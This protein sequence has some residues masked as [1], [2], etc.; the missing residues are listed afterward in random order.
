MRF[1]KLHIIIISLLGTSLA[2]AQPTATTDGVTNVTD[3]SVTFNGTVEAASLT[4]TDYFFEYGTASDLTGASNTGTNNYTG[5][6]FPSPQAISIAQSGLSSETQYYYRLNVIGGGN[7]EGSIENFFT[8]S[9]VYANAISD[10]KV[11]SNSES[12]IHLEWTAETTNNDGYLILYSTGATA[13]DAAA[14]ISNAVAPAGQ[15]YSGPGVLSEIVT[16]SSTNN[17]DITGLTGATQYS[18]A[19]IPFN[20]DES[21]DET[22][23]YNTIT[24]SSFSAFTQYPQP[25]NHVTGI[26]HT[27]TASSI[28]LSF[29]KPSGTP[30]ADGYYISY[31]IGSSAPGNLGGFLDGTA[32]TAEAFESDVDGIFSLFSAASTVTANITGLSAN[33]SYSFRIVPFAS[34]PGQDSTSFNYKT[35]GEPTYTDIYTLAEEPTASITNF[36]KTGASTTQIDFSF[37]QYDISPGFANNGGF[38]LYYQAGAT[39]PGLSG[40]EDGID[41][42]GQTT[43]PA[44]FSVV[45]ADNATSIST[46]G[47]ISAGTEYSFVIIPYN[48]LG[49]T[50][51]TFN[52]RTTAPATLTAWSLSSAPSGEVPDNAN[53]IVDNP[54]ANSFDV[55][56]DAVTADGY[57]A[58]YG[59]SAFD[60]TDLV[61][62]TAPAGQ[63]VTNG[64]V[65]DLGNVNSATISSLTAN[66]DYEVVIIPYNVAT[67]GGPVAETYNY[68]TANATTKSIATICS[69][70]S[71]Q[72]AFSGSSQTA[73]TIDLQWNTV[74]GADRY[75]I[76][77]KE[78]ADV[79]FTPV[80]GDA[81][82]GNADFSL[83]N[84]V[85]SSNKVIFSGAYPAQPFTVTGLTS[86]VEYR[87][88]IFAF[89]STDN[90]Y[91]TVAPGTLSVTTD[92]PSANN[93]LSIVGTAATI[94]SISNDVNNNFITV[95]SF[96]MI[97]GGVDNANTFLSGFDIV[98]GA[99]DFFGNNTIDWSE[100]IAEARLVNTTPAT[101][102][103]K[104]LSIAG[105]GNTLSVAIA[106]N[107][108]NNASDFGFIADGSSVRMELQIKLDDAITITNIDNKNFSFE[109]NPASITVEGLSSGFDTSGGTTITS[110]PAQNQIQVD[111]SK[112]TFTTQ[113]P[114]NINATEN[115]SPQ[116]VI[117]ARDANNNIDLDFTSAF[118][119]TNTDGIP[120]NNAPTSGFSAGEFTFPSNFSYQGSGDGTLTLTAGAV[121]GSSSA[122][123]VTPTINFAELTIGLNA[124]TLQSGTNDQAV[125]GVSIQAVGDATLNELIF[126]IDATIAAKLTNV[127]IYESANAQFDGVG[128]ETL[129]SPTINIDNPGGT[130]TVTGLASAFTSE[131]K[132][133][134]IVVDVAT[135]VN[136]FDTPDLTF[137]IDNADIDFNETVNINS[138]SFNKLY[139]FEDITS[140]TVSN[141]NPEFAVISDSEIASTFSLTVTYN[142]EMDA[143]STPTITFPTENPGASLSFQAGSSSW[144]SGNMVYTAVFNITD[145][146]LDLENIDVRIT[147]ARD[148]SNNVQTVYNEADVFSIDTRNPTVSIGL[149]NT[150]VTVVDNTVTLTATFVEEMNPAV[151]PVFNV[152][153]TS[154]LS[155]QGAGTWSV[156]NTVYTQI[157]EHNLTEEEITTNSIQVSTAEDVFGNV[158]ITNSSSNFQVDTEPAKI[159]SISS[160]TANG[161]KKPGDVIIVSLNFDDNVSVSGNPYLELNAGA[162]IATFSSVSGSTINFTYTVGTVNSGENTSDLDVENIVLN[163]GTIED[164]NAND[165]N[166][167]L[168]IAPNRLIDNKDIEVDT[169]PAQILNVTSSTTDG[170]YN[171]PDII[172]IDI[173]FDEVVNVQGTPA[174]NLNSG[175]Q[176]LYNAG[177]G[178]TVLSFNYTV[179]AGENADPLDYVNINSLSAGTSIRDN[180]LIDVN[181]TLPALSGGNSLSD[182]SNIII[183]TEAPILSG[184]PF[185]PAN[186]SLNVSHTE[187]FKTEFV[188]EVSGA[189]TNNIRLIR[190]SDD[191]VIATYDG[192]NFFGIANLFDTEISSIDLSADIAD[193]TK[194]YFEFD[195]GSVVDRAGNHFAGFSGNSSWSFTSAG[196]ARIDAFSVAACVGELFTIEGEY[197]TGVTQLITGAGPTTTYSQAE[198]DV[199]ADGTEITF[200]VK[201]NTNSGIIELVKQTGESNNTEDFSTTS[202]TGILVGPSAAELF[203]VEESGNPLDD[204]CN[205]SEGGVLNRA[206][207]Q[208][209]VTG[210]SGV[211]NIILNNGVSDTLISGYDNQDT[212]Y[213]NPPS[214][215]ANTYTLV[216]VVDDDSDLSSCGAP[217]LGSPVD[218]I[219]YE[220]SKV[221]AGG[222]SID[223]ETGFGLVTICTAETDVL[224]LSDVVDMGTLPSILG[225]VTA[226][227]WTVIGASA[228]SGGFNV[229]KS[230]KSSTNLQPTYYISL[231]DVARGEVV[232]ELTST[233]PADPNP[234]SPA[235]DRLIIRFISSSRATPQSP[236]LTTCQSVLNDELTAI[237]QLNAALSGGATDIRW[238][239]ADD[240]EADT[241]DGT[242]G[243]ADTED[244]T[245]FTISTTTQNPFYKASPNELNNNFAQVFVKATLGSCEVQTDSSRVDINITELPSPTKSGTAGLNRLEVCSGETGVRFRLNPSNTNSRFSWSITNAGVDTPGTNDKNE[246]STSIVNGFYGSTIDVDFKEVTE[247]TQE[248]LTVYEINNGCTSEA[249]TFDIT[250][251]RPTVAEILNA[252]SSTINNSTT[253]LE[254]I[255]QGGYT[256]DLQVGG[257]FTG[258]GVVETSD[259]R[260]LLN[261]TD[262][263]P[264]DVND[265]LDDYII[266]YTYPT[267]LQNGTNTCPATAIARFDVFDEENSFPNLGTVYCE[268]DEVFTINLDN[269]VLGDNNIVTDIYVTT[270]GTEKGVVFIAPDSTN[271]SATFNPA[272]TLQENGGNPNITVKYATENTVTGEIN[273]E[274]GSQSVIVNPLPSLSPDPINATYCDTDANESLTRNETLN[275]NNS[276]TFSI[277]NEGLPSD[278]GLLVFNESPRSFQLDFSVM[279]DYFQETDTDS[280]NLNLSYKYTSDAGCED[281]VMLQTTIY[282]IPEA[283]E[284]LENY[285]F[286]VENNQIQSVETAIIDEN[287]SPFPVN[288]FV[289]ESSISVNQQIAQGDSFS[290]NIDINR[291]V[292]DY[293]AVRFDEV[294]CR[295][296]IK[297]INYYRLERPAINWNSSVFA[298]NQ[299]IEFIANDRNEDNNIDLENLTKTWSIRDEEGNELS[300]AAEDQGNNTL[301]YQF[302]QSGIYQITYAIAD[303]VLGLSVN[304]TEQMVAIPSQSQLTYDFNDSEQGWLQLAESGSESSWERAIPQ[305]GFNSSNESW[306]TNATGDYSP[307]EKSFLYSPAF[308]ISNIEQP[309]LSFDL[310][311]D[312]TG[313]DGLII[314]YS[315]DNLIV[316]DPEKEWNTLGRFNSGL[317]WYNSDELD[318]ED[319]GFGIGWSD[320]LGDTAISLNAKHVLDEILSAEN[321]GS[322]VLFRF[323]LSSN[324][325]S[326]TNGVAIDNF[327]IESRNRNILVEY[328]GNSG[329]TDV[330]EMNALNTNA[331]ADFSWINYRT[332]TNDPFYDL[333]VSDVVTRSYFYNA[334]NSSNDFVLDG[335]YNEGQRFSQNLADLTQRALV[336]SIFELDLDATADANNSSLNITADVSLIGDAQ[337]P[338]NTHL[339]VAVL[340]K[341]LSD[342]GTT[343]FNVLQD[344]L[345]SAQG[346]DV[347]EEGSFEF[348]YSPSSAVKSE[349]LIA[350]AFLQQ[351]SGDASKTVYQSAMTSNPLTL[352][353]IITASNDQL[354]E[355]LKVYPNPA[356]DKV[357]VAVKGA[358]HD[359]S[360]RLMDVQGKLVTEVKLNKSN[361]AVEINTAGFSSGLYSL[362]IFDNEGNSQQLKLAV[363][364]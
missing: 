89:N 261:T 13:P 75:L 133:F 111:A 40:V 5:A 19:I 317:N 240:A 41:P 165:A 277:L 69:A 274:A 336:S 208:I 80:N 22:Y 98:A 63:S 284:G 21:N 132:N 278:L 252:P 309:V 360:I 224:D 122:V 205:E 94:N 249:L 324:S 78:A 333:A 115:M 146:N 364:H 1:L 286:I 325:S 344:F 211:F 243:F 17:V 3:N 327:S 359:L 179:A 222:A 321:G 112:F 126:H 353:N 73:T 314:E 259:G 181:R 121:S 255:G 201:A 26:S 161:L 120:M 293:Y 354:F 156:G 45:T 190:F 182:N 262:L 355:E 43:A 288:W 129:L 77:A 330:S 12:S 67:D 81:Y 338:E 216:S 25:A 319:L 66:T 114:A 279:P 339:I 44:L 143:A 291:A 318:L 335:S 313:S 24:Y 95:L 35:D 142:E 185:K 207:I 76:L 92:L 110:D 180:A 99:S 347:T 61:D 361:P 159:T 285:A 18:F 290:P 350:V 118:V 107:E 184:D 88:A 47:G 23:N 225:D 105:T 239:R 242:W 289:D 97:D 158:M 168:P 79:D 260:Y 269:A 60:E 195:A 312:L 253:N 220:R 198:F 64:T 328:F 193:T 177:S 91:N 196:P 229:S 351:F 323:Y 103:I 199:N 157:F 247:D 96:D 53:F 16:G 270:D 292:E 127:R 322:Q 87:F 93:T 233:D 29:T 264:T 152:S 134:L 189:G 42:D 345:P 162:A 213:L 218:I 326:T 62:G 282:K 304:T 298:T 149:D 137:S 342:N 117:E 202:S 299:T 301:S 276:F 221:E 15:T 71:N 4:S 183:D 346:T 186:D 170:Y 251:R 84:T 192:I 138:F 234:C 38:V 33:T 349:N 102:V 294:N 49:S 36:Q 257:Y 340:S 188:E 30:Q 144:S 219:K 175:G 254:L 266:T 212:L 131:T 151:I 27:S 334:F 125:I 100:I 187:S 37:D 14:E 302:T 155:E 2:V 48:V 272:L 119:V 128:S 166:L 116:P 343:Y 135:T 58:I 57:V 306:V 176:A 139:S 217:D 341:E 203:V 209:N 320:N 300:I 348:S 124:G 200:F 74:A 68:F 280:L 56:Y 197:F 169:N 236:S 273:L 167:T 9:T 316:E 153:G 163:G 6:L 230:Q 34:E 106:G 235:F 20:S 113:P 296:D 283:P 308:D 303:E 178:S 108:N 297:R 109:I 256:D 267:V 52:Y 246:I 358:Q 164:T 244:A 315:T 226:G 245:V 215:G 228:S 241:H 51:P 70:P 271:Y 72:A 362:I 154:N 311:L 130:I 28:E 238:S 83:A 39:P 65:V 295:S 248:T 172:V 352:D 54:T 210:G 231:D 204:I 148:K 305:V 268:S 281:S 223:T 145:Q 174:L 275:P 7:D 86:N 136:A 55:A 206:P 331:Q 85:G 101:D 265:P 32:G 356:S 150:L 11:R 307:R 363:K 82:T 59:T 310:W 31:R 46:D 250:I 329:A 258:K 8:Y 357:I 171:E 214:F 10:F 160:P 140:P 232:L 337:I 332:N 237:T 50:E 147:G 123:N 194:Y 263:A 191:Q 141:I 227:E 104:T 173:T 287:E 90:C